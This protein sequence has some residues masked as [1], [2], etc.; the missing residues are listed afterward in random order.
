[1]ELHDRPQLEQRGVSAPYEAY[2]SYDYSVTS[3]QRTEDSAVLTRGV[4]RAYTR[5]LG[6]PTRLCY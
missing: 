1:M 3:F 6:S 2:R 5:E 4:Q